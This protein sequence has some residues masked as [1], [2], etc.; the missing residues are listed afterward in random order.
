MAGRLRLCA[1]VGV[2]TQHLFVVVRRRSCSVFGVWGPAALLL[3][4][5][6][7]ERV[8]C[9]RRAGWREGAVQDA[10]VLELD[11]AGR[12]RRFQQKK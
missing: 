6:L 8:L 9:A 11:S 7:C 3:A 5:V 12:F 4:A 2:G 10:N 1:R